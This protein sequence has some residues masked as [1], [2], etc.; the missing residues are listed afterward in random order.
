MAWRRHRRSAPR[1]AARLRQGELRRPRFLFLQR[2]RREGRAWVGCSC[3]C[4]R[5]GAGRE[6]CGVSAGRGGLGAE[7]GSAILAVGQRE[8]AFSGRQ[9]PGAARRWPAGARIPI[10]SPLQSSEILCEP[11][12]DAFVCAFI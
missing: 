3:F 1:P 6:K 8:A 12:P 4:S 11:V 5:P 9:R 10:I 7:E 2:W